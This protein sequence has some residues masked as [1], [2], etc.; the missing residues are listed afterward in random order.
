[1]GV[2][3]SQGFLRA[4]IKQSLVAAVIGEANAEV[5]HQLQPQAVVGAAWFFRLDSKDKC[6]RVSC[7][8]PRFLQWSKCLHDL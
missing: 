1:M 4:S 3:W 2:S 7:H 8:S 5:L 6:F